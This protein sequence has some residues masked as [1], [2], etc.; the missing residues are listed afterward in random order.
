MCICFTGRE[1]PQQFYA[2][3]PDLCRKLQGCPKSF[4]RMQSS[5][6]NVD[7]R[8]CKQLRIISVELTVNRSS[9]QKLK[10]EFF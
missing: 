7:Q 9:G 1:V 5:Y 6:A 4:V 3:S 10:G 2:F 8:P